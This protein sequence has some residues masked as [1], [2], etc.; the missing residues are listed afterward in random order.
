MECV[1]DT[2][3]LV[4]DTLENSELHERASRILDEVDRLF[5]PS[6]V[7]EEFVY[8]LMELEVDTAHIK[9]KLLEFVENEEIEPI[10]QTHIRAAVDMITAEKTSFKRF[11]DSLILA[12]ARE[13]NLPLLTFDRKLNGDCLKYGIKTLV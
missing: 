9:R 5:I 2:N 1:V 12:V 4:Y 13:K 11:N 3:A 8:V 7:M 6:V 10:S